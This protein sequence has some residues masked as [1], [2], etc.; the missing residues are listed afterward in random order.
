MAEDLD[1]LVRRVDEDRWLASRFAT[2]DVRARLVA[3]YAVNYEIARTAEVVREAALGDVRL[4]WWRQSLHEI[5]DGKPPHAHP[6]LTAYAA[7]GLV[8]MLSLQTVDALIAARRPDWSA[9]PFA[10]A[11]EFD[12][13]LDASAGNVMR[14]AIEAC[15]GGADENDRFVHLVGWVWGCVGL[16]RTQSFWTARGRSFIPREGGSID[17]LLERAGDALAELLAL[18]RPDAALFPAVGYVTLA[19]GYLK[20]LQRG[21]NERSILSRQVALIVASATGRL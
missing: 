5:H 12:D 13:Y 15:G 19:R 4:E 3:L 18:P 9:T 11:V 8:G 7:S 21:S 1:Q 20:A 10:T 17:K 2:A 14:L 16:L 6:A